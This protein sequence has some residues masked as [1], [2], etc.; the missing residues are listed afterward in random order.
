MKRLM[1]LVYVLGTATI[2]CGIT[3]LNPDIP[4][5]TLKNIEDTSLPTQ[6]TTSTREVTLETT[7][8]QIASIDNRPK[9]RRK[10][11]LDTDSVEKDD[12]LND[13]A[14]EDHKEEKDLGMEPDKLDGDASSVHPRKGAPKKVPHGKKELRSHGKKELRIDKE[15]VQDGSIAEV[16]V[17]TNATNNIAIDKKGDKDT[18]GQ[19]NAKN[20]ETKL[21]TSKNPSEDANV[22]SNT[23][24]SP[25]SLPNVKTAITPRQ[26]DASFV[27]VKIHCLGGDCSGRKKV[28]GTTTTKNPL[29]VSDS[30]SRTSKGGQGLS[31]DVPKVS[32]LP[33]A[34]STASVST[35]TTTTTAMPKLNA[36]LPDPAYGGS[37]GVVVGLFFALVL[38]AVLLFV[39]FKRLDAVRRRREYRRMNDFLIDGM[40]NDA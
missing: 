36:Q 35:T 2:V 7:T 11:S 21:S 25:T 1:T 8:L 12:D 16:S 30:S 33:S 32:L 26:P 9:S 5:T 24:P 18:S 28:S 29:A 3:T 19:E 17:R 37:T 34:P 22:D 6:D 14:L 39:G 38:T 4:S 20:K 15:T 23:L 40:Y 13:Q 10:P 27:G 31:V